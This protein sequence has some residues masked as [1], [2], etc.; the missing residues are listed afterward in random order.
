MLP[1]NSNEAKDKGC[2]PVSS[3]CVVWQGPDLECIGL[4]KGD[5]ISDV[6]AKMATEL[7]NLIEM[8]DLDGFSLACLAV[9]ASDPVT[10][11]HDLI[12]VLVERICALEGINA[13]EAADG[14]PVSGSDCPIN[15]VVDI[16]PCFYY[17]NP[18]GDTITTMQLTDYVHAIGNRICD[19]LSDIAA[20]QDG[21]QVLD[22]QV[23]NVNTPAIAAL[24]ADKAN[25]NSLY[26]QLS[27]KTDPT[28]STKYITDALRSVENSLIG[29]QD[30]TGTPTELYQSILKEGFLNDSAKLFG[31]G[32][33]ASIPGW[34]DEPQ[35]VSDTLGN[36]WLSIHDIR[37]AVAY[38]QENCCSTGCSDI[39]L[40]FRSALNVTPGNS[41]LTVF[42]D[43]STGFTSDWKQCSG[44]TR[45]VVTD[46]YG[47]STTF[48]TDLIVLIDNPSGYSID[49]TATSIDVTTDLTVTAETCFMNTAVE[50]QCEKDYVY[51]I[52]STPD[53]PSNVLTVLSNSVSY[54]FTST[55]GYSYI[56]SIYY[57]GGSS[58]VATQIIASPGTIV[59]NTIFGLLET[60]QYEIQVVLVDTTGGE[61]PC[62]RQAFTTLDNNCVPPINPV[63]Q[64]T[65]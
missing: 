28:G 30:A 27:T 22:N 51:T 15:C 21:Q 61:T 17:L 37:S 36:I 16:A 56:V 31:T 41:I 47:N 40:N 8:F 23:N 39:Y 25:K 49:I 29:T 50:T 53:C 11:I 54:Q 38:M 14:T 35:K 2:N 59:A 10:N 44:D 64:I 12:Q 32:N 34:V 63:V 42:T 65:I 18:Q 5:T 4:C 13:T 1:T 19:I 9:P 7:C 62:A 45:I 52:Q 48:R 55:V 3:N 60:T 58:P 26:Y 57:Y 46:V 20:L 33:M 43:G 24:E 6:I